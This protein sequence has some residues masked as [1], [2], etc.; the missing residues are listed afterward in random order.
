MRTFPL[1]LPDRMKH[2]P[3]D[4]RG[5]PIPAFVE[6]LP[7]GSRDFRIM[8]RAHF[9]K[10]VRHDAC[11]ICGDRLGSFK[12]FAVGPMC[13]CNKISAEPPSHHECAEFAAVACP[14]MT[15]PKAQRRKAGLD[16][17]D[18]QAVPGMIERN[19]GVT[20][21][22]TTKTYRLVRVGEDNVL[23]QMGEPARLEFY[24][25]ARPATRIEVDDSIVS[26]LPILETI[27]QQEGPDALAAFRKAVAA[28]WHLID[29]HMPDLPEV[30]AT[31]FR[32]AAQ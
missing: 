6:T 28:M 4:P 19:P 18:H 27:A 16:E 5:Y 11:W 13:V 26:G 10:A 8:S 22:W 31:S 21:I 7:D 1:D 20:A 24:A 15:L 32:E 9:A 23:F 25:R 2:L 30:D 3:L 12:S 29:R 14:F 17:I